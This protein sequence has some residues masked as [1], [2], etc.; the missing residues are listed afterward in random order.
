MFSHNHLQWGWLHKTGWLITIQVQNHFILQITDIREWSYF[1]SVRTISYNS[2]IRI[3]ASKQFSHLGLLPSR[4]LGVFVIGRSKSLR[5]K[6]IVFHFKSMK[7]YIGFWSRQIVSRTNCPSHV[8][9][10]GCPKIVP[11]Y[12]LTESPV[13]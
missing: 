1:P 9:S 7:S 13:V 5:L 3:A 10:S 2:K 4:Y 11:G 8:L 6:T 12:R